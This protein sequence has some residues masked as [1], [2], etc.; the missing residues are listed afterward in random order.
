M[1]LSGPDLGDIGVFVAS[2]FFFLGANPRRISWRSVTSGCKVWKGFTKGTDRESSS[3]RQ[4]LNFTWGEN[5]R[6]ARGGELHTSL[7]VHVHNS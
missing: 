5:R 6:K 4:R 3:L 7:Y 1:N 2:L